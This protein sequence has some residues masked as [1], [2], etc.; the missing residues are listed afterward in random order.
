[1]SHKD[2]VLKFI[3]NDDINSFRRYNKINNININQLIPNIVI[4]CCKKTSLENSR[5]YNWKF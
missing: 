4:E 1:M 3:S 2:N 5:I